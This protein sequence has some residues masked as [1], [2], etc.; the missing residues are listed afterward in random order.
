MAPPATETVPTEVPPPQEEVLGAPLVVTLDFIQEC[1]VDARVDG[2]P[3]VSRLF[4]AGESIQLE[5][6]ETV[7]LSLGNGGGVEAQVNNMP[8]GLDADPGEVVSVT[9]DLATV[10]RLRQRGG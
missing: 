3:Q 8:L 5:G 6:E 2:A 9:I 10:E 7:E 4:V 1:W